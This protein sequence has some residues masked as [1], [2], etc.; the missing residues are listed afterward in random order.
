M[1]ETA[2]EA[3][4]LVE[5][6]VNKNYKDLKHRIRKLHEL[7]TT[8]GTN[9]FEFMRALDAVRRAANHGDSRR[10]PSRELKA[11]L[12]QAECLGRGLAG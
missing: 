1:A 10:D 12:E 7:L 4:E 11:L 6:P 2:P 8:S 9:S 5:D 3:H